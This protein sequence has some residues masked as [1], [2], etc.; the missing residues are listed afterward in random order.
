MSPYVHEI[1]GAEIIA[2]MNAAD[3]DTRVVGP[4]GPPLDATP[5]AM[6]ADIEAL[7]AEARTLGWIRTDAAAESL[8]VQ[9][10]TL[11]S[12]LAQSDFSLA[13]RTARAFLS[14]V[15]ATGCTTFECPPTKALTS[16][17][18]ALMFFNMEYLR[19]LIP[20][21][22]PVCTGAVATPRLF[23]PPNHEMVDVAIGGVTDPDGDLTT[24]RWT[25]VTQ[26][27]QVL[28]P[29]S[30]NHCPDADLISPS[31]DLRLRAERAGRLN[32][33]VYRVQFE[34]TDD[35]GATCSG[36]V[37]VCMPHEESTTPTCVEDSSIY[38]SFVCP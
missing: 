38:D 6:A 10:S 15:S 34:A 37:K 28:E 29:G 13:K 9:L 25:S 24:T 14:D 7:R 8:R 12:A 32:G 36:T 26:D 35:G 21:A 16:D 27:E 4:V 20:N 31:G 17:A 2:A 3:F 30:G 19:S 33:R 5:A 1:P 18:Y 11:S 22:A 23:W